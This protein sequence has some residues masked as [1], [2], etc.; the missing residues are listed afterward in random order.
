MLSL[1]FLYKAQPAQYTAPGSETNDVRTV[2]FNVASVF[3]NRFDD[4]DS[5][6]RCARFAAYMNQCKPDLIGT[7]E[8]NI[9]WYKALP[10]HPAGLRC[11]RR[12]AGRRR[13][14]LEQ[15]DEPGLLE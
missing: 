15:R 13:Y 9:Y 5:M 14:G 6:T 8:M 1:C 3:G 11:L 4:T 2:T 7:Q 10:N 12:A